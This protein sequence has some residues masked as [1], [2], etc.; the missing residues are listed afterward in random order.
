MKVN[1]CRFI[2]QAVSRRLLS[3]AARVRAPGSGH[4]GFV[5]DKAALGQ[6]FSE[7]FCFLFHS[8]HR[9]LHTHPLSG[10]GAICQMVADAPIGLSLTPP[11]ET[12]KHTHTHT[13]THKHEKNVTFCV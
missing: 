5:V 9:L 4:V 1:T 12:N 6:F 8:L 2:A 10:A 13:H 3:A 7:S 11:Q